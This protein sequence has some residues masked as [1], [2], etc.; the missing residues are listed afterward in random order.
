M[1]LNAMIFVF[2]ML[3][4]NPT[5]SHSSFTFIKR[6]FSSSSFSAIRVVSSVYLR[7]LIFLLAIL[8]P[9]C[10]SSSLTFCVMYFA[11]KLNKQSDNIQFW[12]TPFP[13]LNQAI[14]PCPVLTVASWFAY[15]FLRRQVRWSDSP[16]SK[17]FPQFVVVHAVKCFSVVNEA[18]VDYY[19]LNS[20]PFF[21]IQ[22]MLAIWSPVPLSF[23]HPACTSGSS[24]F[25]YCWSIA[26]RI[27]SITL[28]AGTNTEV[29][30]RRYPTSKGKGEAPERW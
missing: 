3:S 21:M 18:E 7:L 30:V 16:I 14:V 23:L 1:G 6:L 27:L 9:A 19:F 4:F 10:A 15:R 26:W 11:Y 13:I 2:W 29:V 25:M 20:L 22:Q 28:L 12:C 24:Q 8:I 17:N 5:I